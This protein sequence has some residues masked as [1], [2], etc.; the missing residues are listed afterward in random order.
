MTLESDGHIC[1]VRNRLFQCDVQLLVRTFP[2]LWGGVE[3]WCD[4]ES[5]RACQCVYAVQVGRSGLY[6]WLAMVAML[7]EK[8]TTNKVEWRI[9][10][11]GSTPIDWNE[12]E[13]SN[14]ELQITFN[15][16]SHFQGDFCGT[17]TRSQPLFDTLRRRQPSS[18]P[19]ISHS[20]NGEPHQYRGSRSRLLCCLSLTKRN[21]PVD[22]GG[23][24]A[25]LVI[26]A[27]E[28][29]LPLG[30][31]DNAVQTRV[32]KP[33][34][35]GLPSFSEVKFPYQLLKLLHTVATER[36]LNRCQTVQWCNKLSVGW[37][38][39]SISAETGTRAWLGSDTNIWWWQQIHSLADCCWCVFNA[40]E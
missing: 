4:T 7:F 35:L 18:K 30:N 32:S 28:K 6:W 23:A 13:N 19:P 15:L 26:P 1:G 20:W 21:K 40:I 9:E 27:H 22:T 16:T 24:D 25:W 14:K 39:T 12:W 17:R 8:W 3:L 38:S 33:S 10:R 31:L 11:P 37:A 5:L 36:F 34:S 29:D 2:N